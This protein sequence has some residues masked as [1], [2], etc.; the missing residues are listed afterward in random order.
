[1]KKLLLF[2]IVILA[3]F[4]ASA[5]DVIV[6]KDGT[7]V[8][9]KIVQVN[10]NEVVYVKWS[11]INGPQYIM[12]SS[13]VSNINYMD[14]RQDKLSEQSSNSY[15]PGIQQTGEAQYNDNALLV[16]D[17]QRNSGDWYK[18]YKKLKTIGWA[19]GGSCVGAGLIIFFATGAYY[20]GGYP[21]CY[22][23]AAIL[24]V[25]GI[26]TTT[27]C[28]IKANQIKQKALQIAFTPVIQKEIN[29]F[30]KTSLI[31]SVDM[32]RDNQLKRNSL[33]LGL[34]FNF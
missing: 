16:L 28:L 10:D 34:Q 24:V 26:A 29:F 14:G 18:K 6:K 22:I 13:L 17:K 30:G 11:D 33:G 1:M 32:I 9:C 12:D 7:T 20:D 8:L 27:A 23:P 31:A 25:G 3:G 21:S 2:L 5:Q 15:A 19:V 4:S